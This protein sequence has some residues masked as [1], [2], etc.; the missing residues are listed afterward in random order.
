M[1]A[2]KEEDFKSLKHFVEMY[3]AKFPKAIRFLLKDQEALMAFH[4]FQAEPWRKLR[5]SNPIESTFATV[6]LRTSKVRGSFSR[7]TVLTMAFILM[8]SAQKK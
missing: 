8:H 6:K 2:S 3:E 1:A 5:T 4:D 7:L